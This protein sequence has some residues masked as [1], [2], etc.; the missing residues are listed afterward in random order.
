M[1]YAN[2]ALLQI[3]NLLGALIVLEK[4]SFKELGEC[5]LEAAAKPPK[6]EDNMTLL[7]SG[8]TLKVLGFTL[9]H[10]VIRND[11]ETARKSWQSTGLQFESFVSPVS[12]PLSKLK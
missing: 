5:L 10:I 1:L 9:Q 11:K 2:G 4:A 3:G 7:D 12:L 8:D 6:D